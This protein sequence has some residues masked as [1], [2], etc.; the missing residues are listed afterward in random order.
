MNEP[1]VDFTGD[2]SELCN[3]PK[4]HVH[5]A[6]IHRNIQPFDKNLDKDLIAIHE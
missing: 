2:Q 5:F 1:S 4:H 3:L 6:E